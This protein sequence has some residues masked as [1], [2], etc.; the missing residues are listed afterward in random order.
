MRQELES[1]LDRTKDYQ[2]HP[3]GWAEAW[4]YAATMAMVPCYRGQELVSWED[5]LREVEAVSRP[6]RPGLTAE[7][8]KQCALEAL[9][10]RS[11]PGRNFGLEVRYEAWWNHTWGLRDYRAMCEE[12]V[13]MHRDL[14]VGCGG[15]ESYDQWLAVLLQGAPPRQ[16]SL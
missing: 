16:V 10:G 6:N 3:F 9:T 12:L 11:A 15:F 4:Y 7:I 13:N 8:I 5:W 14:D 1:L 2:D